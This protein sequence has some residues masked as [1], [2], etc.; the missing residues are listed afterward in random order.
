MIGSLAALAA[1]IASARAGTVVW[2]GDFDYYSSANDFNN[3]SWGNQ[4]RFRFVALD[5]EWTDHERP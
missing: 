3:W 1:L 5:W 2:S 4:V